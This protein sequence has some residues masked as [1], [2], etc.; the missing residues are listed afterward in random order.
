M[1]NN[2]TMINFGYDFNDARDITDT[3]T[4]EIFKDK[5]VI[6]GLFTKNNLDQPLYN[7]DIHY[8]SA[9]RNYLGKSFPN[10]YGGEVLATIV[11]NIKDN[12]FIKKLFK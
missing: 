1:V 3:T 2:K 7:D 8:T 6:V 9:N 5:I 10:M 11:A 12:S 4:L